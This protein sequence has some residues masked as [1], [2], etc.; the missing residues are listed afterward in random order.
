MCLNIW[1]PMV[2]YLAASLDTPW[3]ILTS[4]FVHKDWLH[5]SQNM[6]SLIILTFIFA[7]TNMHLAK[8]E[9]RRRSSLFL[10]NIFFSAIL[11]NILWVIILPHVKSIGS[12]GIVYA[13]TGIVMAFSLNNTCSNVKM[14]KENWKKS[15]SLK[16]LL[17]KDP[18][19]VC[20]LLVFSS[21]LI[22]IIIDPK[23][24]LSTG[25]S[26]NTFV[27][28]IA[29]LISFLIVVILYSQ[30]HNKI[31]LKSSC[32]NWRYVMPKKETADDLVTRETWLLYYLWKIKGFRGS[33][34]ALSKELGYKDDSSVNKKINKLKQ[35]GYVKEEQ[36]RTGTVFKVTGKG[37]RKIIFLILPRYT[38]KILMV[39][40]FAY[41]FW[42]LL[43]V[44]GIFYV[45]PWNILLIGII[46]TGATGFLLWSY[47]KSE[48]ELL[49]ITKP[50][51]ES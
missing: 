21:L 45:E 18:Q 25:P 24:F 49:K 47:R 34:S 14:L 29:F 1:F 39:L 6:V 43:G 23:G 37:E 3:G 17:K 40:T 22:C 15:E 12:S 26:V 19:I 20:N 9:K 36:T 32:F 8:Q 5:F 2:D 35:K 51:S 33:I 46:S 27:H 31:M 30:E 42:G 10:W 50:E 28:F 7:I 4:L 11:V 16:D 41:L 48:E 38:L 44:F 13:S